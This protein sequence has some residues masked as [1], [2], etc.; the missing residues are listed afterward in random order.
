VSASLCLDLVSVT[1]L[2]LEEIRQLAALG[3]A[4]RAES[5]REEVVVD[6]E[7]E[8]RY[9]ATL[10]TWVEP[11]VALARTGDE[12]VGAAC[13]LAAEIRS[14]GVNAE[15]TLLY[16]RP[17]YRRTRVARKLLRLTLAALPADTNVV[18]TSTDLAPAA[19]RFARSIGA[20]IVDRQEYRQLSLSAL[21]AGRYEALARCPREFDLI[22]WEGHCPD[23]WINEACS[24][25]SLS[26]PPARDLYAPRW[27][28]I[29]EYRDREQHDAVRGA[30]SWNLAIRHRATNELVALHDLVVE[31]EAPRYARVGHVGVNPSYRGL[32]L[33]RLMIANTTLH[34]LQKSD[35]IVELRGGSSVT[36][37]PMI[38]VF[39]RLGYH[40]FAIRLFWQTKAASVVA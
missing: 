11:I 19:G 2:P 21:N 1:E 15:V 5:A 27:L 6:P 31:P 17:A 23:E 38:R 13:V 4:S 37:L 26:S 8:R 3:A 12:V 10:P 40:A 7:L 25:L 33:G 36:N 22:S 39:N 18:G 28:S 34:L 30:L 20:S 32:G 29:N 16:V 24:L 9:W 35:G 14:L